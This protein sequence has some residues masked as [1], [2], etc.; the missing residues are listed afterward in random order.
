MAKAPAISVVMSVYNGERWLKAAIQSILDQSFRDFEFII[1]N[2]GSTDDSEKVIKSFKDHRIRYYK[3]ANKKLVY[4]LNRGV[5]LAR[6][7]LIARMDDDDLAEPER[8]TRQV[9]FLAKHP[10]VA[11]VGSSFEVMLSDKTPLYV[12][13]VFTQFDDIVREMFY[14]NPMGHGSIMMRK[15]IF[16]QVGGYRS[17]Y[18]PNED[19]D[20]WQRI[21]E[22]AELA[23]LP[24]VL[25]HWRVNPAG[26]SQS[27]SQEQT[28]Y[29]Q[30]LIADLWQ[31]T[32]PALL[33]PRQ[34]RQR[35]LFYKQSGELGGALKH[36][37]LHAQLTLAWGLI[38]HGFVMR[39]L[40]HWLNFL[41]HGPSGPKAT[42]WHWL[43]LAHN[44]LNRTLRRLLG[45]LIRRFK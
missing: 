17:I 24:Q 33:S 14:H 22:V 18:G 31:K 34:I 3:Q 4:S 36:R 27:R 13:A 5:K 43:S 9:D 20:L 35:A 19:Y 28:R 6:S 7:P 42:L 23:N 38:T 32:Q 41:V 10:D 30:Q 29:K 2:D 15:S 25:H 8:F 39:G 1:I 11:V 44:W 16:D 37:Y 45:P 40:R 12:E 26:E 21:S